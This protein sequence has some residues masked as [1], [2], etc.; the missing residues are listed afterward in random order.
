[1]GDDADIMNGDAGS[2]RIF[3][4]AGDDLI[5]AG[6]G[7]DT[8]IG[9][10][11]N[12]RFL[13][14][15][16]DGNDVYFG[17]EISGGSSIDTLDMST[18]THAVTVDLGS[19][20]GGQ[21][22]ASGTN[23]G[24]DTLWGVENVTTGAGQDTIRASSVVNVMD[25]GAG[26]DRFVFGSTGA[27]NGDTIIGFEAGDKIDL[28]GI[29]SNMSVA[30]NQAF[31]LITSGALTVAKLSVSYE[32]IDGESYTIV[33]GN[34]DNTPGADFKINVRGTHNLTASDFTL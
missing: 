32:V 12:D 5:N 26:N 13:A 24:S 7:N 27:A 8:V 14:E 9:G 4:D 31:S 28:S 1:G 30:G 33:S 6:A 25:G 18:M 20:I 34:V 2:D 3:G 23:I 21:G 29:D 16:G 19:G 22:S 15:T 11:G 10:A 17:D